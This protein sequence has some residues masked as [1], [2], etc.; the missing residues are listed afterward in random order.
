[1]R[2]DHAAHAR[3]SAVRWQKVHTW[4]TGTHTASAR[5]YIWLPFPVISPWRE[6]VTATILLQEPVLAP[7]FTVGNRRHDRVATPDFQLLELYLD[8]VP[9]VR[10]LD[11]VQD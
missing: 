2:A 8:Q 1:M 11:V 4:A 6:R 5:T 9:N 10:I 7:Q 3:A